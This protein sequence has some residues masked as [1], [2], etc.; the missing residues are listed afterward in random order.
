MFNKLVAFV[1]TNKVE[2]INRGFP[3]IGAAIGVGLAAI[4]TTL[5]SDEEPEGLME[6]ES[7]GGEN[8]L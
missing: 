5:V 8:S 7:D 6:D 3:I 1:V 2:L 4:I